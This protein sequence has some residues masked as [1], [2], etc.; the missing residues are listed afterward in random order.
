MSAVPA[1]LA[2]SEPGVRE[3]YDDLLR[4]A[5]QCGP[6][7]VEE[8]K[9]SLHLVRKS[10]FVGVH[11]RKK[12]LVVTLKAAGPVS[13]ARIFKSEQVSKSRWHH[14]VKLASAADVDTELLVWMREA[15]EISA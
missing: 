15:Y 11:P 6:F 4:M 13:S 7:E 3:L 8:K 9:T 10:A 1:L 12:H 14:E 2:A 5:G